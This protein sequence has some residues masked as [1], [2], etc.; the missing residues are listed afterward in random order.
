MEAKLATNIW[1]YT[2]L[3]VANK[4][5]FTA[6]IGAYYLTIPG[7]TPFW[8]GLFLLVSNGASLIFDI[9]SS[10]IADKIGHKES[11]VLSRVF[12]LVSTALFLFATN[13]A[14]LIAASI[15]LSMGLAFLS[16]V[17]SAFM[18]ETLRGLGRED[19]YRTVMGKAS[20]IGFVLPALLAVVVPFTVAISY[21]IPFLIGL[22]FDIVGLAAAFSLVRPPV[23]ERAAGEET[24][25]YIA[26]IRQGLALRFFRIAL[27]SSVVSAFIFSVDV[28]RGPYQIVLGV[29]VVLFGIFFGTGRAIASLML[30]NSGRLHKL[31]GDV[32]A[33]QRVQIVI[34]GILLFILGLVA[35]PWV[36]V[37]VF[38]IDNALKYGFSQV[39][40]GYQLDV[41]SNHRFK[42]TILSTG[43]Q[44]GNVL[45]MIGTGLMGLSI[46]HY[47]Y[48]HTF[49]VTSVLFMLVVV[50]LNFF[51]QKHPPVGR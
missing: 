46:E 30:A 50:P 38:I 43:D 14:W 24:T 25:N 47:G 6:I 48:Q 17:G 16:G 5:V 26:V 21:K 19:E 34:Y 28:F 45:M 49:L 27:F 37:A 10:Y 20:S 35:N 15:L 31:I 29:P 33:F 22:V 44:L 41:I 11:I 3:L 9:P 42:A 36:V 1:K 2:V 32:H 8:I 13:I 51:I 18:H 12:I 7:V 4:R 23:R 40:R 39:D